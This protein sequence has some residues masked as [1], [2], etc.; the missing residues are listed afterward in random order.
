MND[1][2]NLVFGQP[3]SELRIK[4]AG[5]IEKILY[6]R[7]HI[8]SDL[9]GY[10][11]SLREKGIHFG[12]TANY[13]FLNAPFTEDADLQSDALVSL[14]DATFGATAAKIGKTLSDEYI[15]A[16]IEKGKGKYI[17]ADKVVDLSTAYS[18]ETTWVFKNAHHD[19]LEPCMDVIRSFLNGTGE[20]VDSVSNGVCFMIYNE[21]AK[22]MEPMTA[23]NC[24][25]LSFMKIGK[26]EPTIGS[27]FKAFVDF[28]KMFFKL[29]G[30]LFRGELDLGS[31]F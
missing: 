25:D 27:A 31:L 4:Y 8:S 9:K 18:P 28:C 23:D 26:E 29:I 19:I 2:L 13:G 17:S 10:Y 16:R 30:M 24:G 11:D 3:G 7:E 5:L 6:Y 14:E 21:E 1:A 12:F 22:I 15:A 20:T